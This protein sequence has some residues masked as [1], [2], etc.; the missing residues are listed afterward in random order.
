MLRTASSTRV[1]SPCTARGQFCTAAQRQVPVVW[2]GRRRRRDAPGGELIGRG[3][4]ARRDAS[5]SAPR[6]GARGGQACGRARTSGSS[7][8]GSVSSDE[9]ESRICGGG[10]RA[11]THAWSEASAESAASAGPRHRRKGGRRRFRQSQ[12]H[13]R[14]RAEA[15]TR[16]AAGAL[17]PAATSLAFPIVSAGDQLSFRMSR[18]ILPC[19]LILG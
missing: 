5:P 1:P 6:G 10:E 11:A 4:R 14:C 9:M 8:L 7:G 16:H 2:S 17:L 19:A 15:R 13:G 12:A 18:Q 3:G